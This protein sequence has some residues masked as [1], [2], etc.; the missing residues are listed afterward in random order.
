MNTDSYKVLLLGIG[1]TGLGVSRI[2]GENYAVPGIKVFGIK[3]EYDL[4]KLSGN[5]IEETE[6][7][8]LAAHLGVQKENSLVTQAAE[9]AKKMGKTVAAVLTTPRIFEGEKAVMSAM[10]TAQELGRV[11]DASLI[12]NQETFNTPPEEGCTFAELINSLV[13]IEETIA[14]CIQNMLKLIANSG[15]I[16]IELEDLKTALTGSDT[17][18]IASGIGAGENRIGFAIE[19]ALSSP[20]M[21][22]CDLTTAKRVLI[23]FLAPKTSPV[24][25]KEIN[26][27]SEFI[28]TLPSRADLNWGIGE[29]DDDDIVSVIILTSGFDVKLPE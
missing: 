1:E 6:L 18:T 17:F 21:R 4:K 3:N 5:V 10:E 14:E 2:I 25:M 12:I 9:I 15:A 13:A 19:G 20:L 16:T 8:I 7:V 23:K 22:N 28:E 24:T 11:V 26:A 29:S 27:V